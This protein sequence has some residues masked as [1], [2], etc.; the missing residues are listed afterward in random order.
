[1]SKGERARSG[2]GKKE[3]KQASKKGRK[4]SERAMEKRKRFE[5]EKNRTDRQQLP[6]LRGG[7]ELR[8]RVLGPDA[9]DHGRELGEGLSGELEV[10]RRKREKEVSERNGEKKRRSI[11]RWGE[12]AS[13]RT[14]MP[15]Y[16]SL[17]LPPAPRSTLLFSPSSRLP[18]IDTR[19]R[20]KRQSKAKKLR[21]TLQK[22]RSIHSSPFRR[23]R[24]RRRAASSPPSCRRRRSRLQCPGSPAR[25]R[26]LR[27]AARSTPRRSRHRCRRR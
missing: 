26:R 7:L 15:I 3:R 22:T 16:L 5:R 9:L 10:W 21:N 11:A 13:E 25:L 24:R 27:R 8:R 2:F 20:N 19:P 23:R 18:A 4:K 14:T 12:R 17:S 6:E 1:M